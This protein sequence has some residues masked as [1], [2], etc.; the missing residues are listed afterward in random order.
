MKQ[1]DDHHK[2][3]TYLFYAVIACSLKETQVF[4]GLHV[5]PSLCAADAAARGIKLLSHPDK[6]ERGRWTGVPTST[7]DRLSFY[8]PE[9]ILTHI[10]Q[11]F[12]GE[13]PFPSAWR[14]RSVGNFIKQTNSK[15]TGLVTELLNCSHMFLHFAVTPN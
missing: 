4:N 2:L 3:R 12:S 13:L 14:R 1:R 5:K 8:I 7:T 9:A 6:H 15:K 10:T 11:F